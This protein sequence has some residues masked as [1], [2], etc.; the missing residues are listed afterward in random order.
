M[1]C[2]LQQGDTG[3]KKSDSGVSPKSGLDSLKGLYHEMD[4]A[5]YYMSG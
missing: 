2:I 3:P 4:S 1:R 5:F